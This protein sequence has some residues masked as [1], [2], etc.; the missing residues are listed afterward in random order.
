MEQVPLA[1][2][3]RPQ[4]LDEIVGQEHLLGE[5]GFIANLVQSKQAM[6]ILLWGPPG[7]GKTTLARLYAKALNANFVSFSA[8]FSGVG[9]LKKV[10]K[11]AKEISFFQKRTVLFVDEIHRFNKAQQDGFLPYI[12]DGTIILIGA[13]TENPSFALNDA[14]LSRAQVLTLKSLSL[15][16][17]DEILRR[18]EETFS[19]L[20]LIGDS[21]E[22]LLN[23]SQGDGRY[24]LNMVEALRGIPEEKFDI[25]TLQKILQR[26]AALFDKTGDG[27][28]NL[29]SA[30]HKSV[31]GS[32]PDAA[33]YWF[34]RMLEGGEDPLFIARRLIRMAM[35]DVGLADPTALTLAMSARESYH[36]LGS[37]EGEL[38]LAE[39]VVYL[40]LAPKSNSIYTAYEKARKV[41]ASTGH[42]MPPKAILN[43]PTKLMGEQGY[44]KGYIYDHDTKHGFSGQHYF[45]EGLPRQNFYKPVERGFEREMK[46]RVQY[47]EQLRKK[48]Q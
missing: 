32:D 5:G 11:Q 46:Q 42:L 15:S 34:A 20:N 3:L 9:D 43:A 47:F 35:E 22:Y 45:P 24:L 38:A 8:V 23:M 1:D 12:E 39:V 30:L 31:R 2:R 36:V 13:T 48:L 6:S 29:I 33:L 27:H 37:P 4:S 17:L 16:A 21:R 14:L 18:Y 41:A 7:S 28:H 40:A 44:S 19:S 26:R 25:P 10:V